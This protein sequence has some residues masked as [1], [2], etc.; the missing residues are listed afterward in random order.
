MGG[1][2]VH[3]YVQKSGSVITW[4]M[5]TVATHRPNIRILTTQAHKYNAYAYLF[6][7]NEPISLKNFE[8][9][10]QPRCASRVTS[11]QELLELAQSSTVDAPLQRFVAEGGD[12]GRVSP[13][14]RGLQTLLQPPQAAPWW[15]PG[16]PVLELRPWQSRLFAYLDEE[17]K[18]RQIFWVVG[19]P[20]AG[21]TTFSMW[22]EN[23][24]NMAGGVLNLVACDST[25]NALHLYRDQAVVIVDYPLGYDWAR[26]SE[27]VG[28]LCECFSEYGSTRHSTKYLGRRCVIRC[29]CVVMAN[30]APIEEVR[31][32]NVVLIETDRS[33]S[34]S[35]STLPM[36]SGSDRRG[37]IGDDARSRSRSPH[38][39][40]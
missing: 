33:E 32:R 2:H 7:E 18:R 22:L 20:N 35:A 15:D 1:F 13:V 39:R 8:P 29:H 3:V 6:K 37:I 36:G 21:K 23:P 14:Q 24:T 31:H 5:L 9:P 28:N 11:S 40:L 4:D 12:L 25:T 10:E 16:Y 17:P 27:I 19:P 38:N 30:R 34:L 26:K